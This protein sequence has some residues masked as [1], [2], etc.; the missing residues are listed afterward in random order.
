M[1]RP[2]Q[3]QQQQQQ[4]GQAALVLSV[5]ALVSCLGFLNSVFGMQPKWY[6]ISMISLSYINIAS[7]LF[8]K[9]TWEYGLNSI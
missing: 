1:K 5:N 9:I 3:Q 8:L 4:N 6:C 2:K 7:M